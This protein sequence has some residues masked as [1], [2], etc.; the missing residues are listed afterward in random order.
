L[1]KLLSGKILRD[2]LALD[3]SAL[4]ALPPF[5]EINRF[6]SLEMPCDV[7]QFIANSCP[8]ETLAEDSWRIPKQA[9]YYLARLAIGVSQEQ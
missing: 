7:L 8:S 6:F 3:F 5:A 4:Y 2:S 9:L 1:P